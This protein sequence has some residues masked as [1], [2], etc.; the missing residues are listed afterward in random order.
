MVP[1]SG[2][3]G[4]LHTGPPLLDTQSFQQVLAEQARRLGILVE[5][6]ARPRPRQAS[7]GGTGVAA[8]AAK[9]KPAAPAS[10]LEISSIHQRVRNMMKAKNVDAFALK[11]P[12]PAPEAAP[13]L[14]AG[15]EERT[16][17]GSGRKFYI[18]HNS[19]VRSIVFS[20][21]VQLF[22]ERWLGQCV[23]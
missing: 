1:S 23:C 6:E 8:A 12:T 11:A 20:E 13:Q 16:E 3:Q 7:P 19:K 5:N 18:D 17:A 22:V 21:D 14:P 10:S 9:R 2:F 15:W 4:A